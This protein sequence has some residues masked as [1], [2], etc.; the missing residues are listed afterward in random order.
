MNTS[1]RCV[2]AL[3]W[4]GLLWAAPLNAQRE[5]YGSRLGRIEAGQP[6]YYSSGTGLYMEAVNGIC[7]RKSPASTAGSGA[8]PTTRWTH[9]GAISIPP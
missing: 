7:R 2:G 3:C 6:I 1:L 8:T 5:D 9:T 4:V